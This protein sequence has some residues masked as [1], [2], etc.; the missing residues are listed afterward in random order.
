MREDGQIDRIQV[1][2]DDLLLDLLDCDLDVSPLSDARGAQG[3]DHH[4]GDVLDDDGGAGDGVAGEEVLL[5]GWVGG[6]VAVVG[7]GEGWSVVG[8]GSTYNG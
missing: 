2:R 3:F 8:I 4:G 6:W 1:S 7:G 5:G